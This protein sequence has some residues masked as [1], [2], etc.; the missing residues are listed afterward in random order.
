MIL[1]FHRAVA[2]SSS[3]PVPASSADRLVNW[4]LIDHSVR[5]ATELAP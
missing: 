4:Y 1:P 3:V 2:M 5:T